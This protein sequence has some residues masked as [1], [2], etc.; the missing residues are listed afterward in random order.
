MHGVVVIYNT[1]YIFDKFTFSV[2]R[3][4][5]VLLQY[6]II[7]AKGTIHFRLMHTGSD[8]NVTFLVTAFSQYVFGEN[9]FGVSSRCTFSVYIFVKVHFW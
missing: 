1:N 8:E 6:K 5:R 2:S 4:C 7:F 9:I 3:W